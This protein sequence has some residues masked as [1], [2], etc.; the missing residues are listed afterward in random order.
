MIERLFLQLW[1]GQSWRYYPLRW[2]LM[3]ITMLF[4]L[5]VRLRYLGYRKGWL[6]HYRPS[7]PVIVVGNLTVGGT[8]KTPLVIALCTWLRS[9]GYQPAVISRGYGRQ[10]ESA[11]L[12]VTAESDPQM[13]GDEPLLIARASGCEVYVSSDRSAAAEMAESDGA[14]I[15]VADD[16]LQHYRLARDIE[17][18]VIDGERG[19]GNGLCLPA[20]PLREPA[21]RLDQVDGVVVNGGEGN[22]TFSMQLK[23]AL[24]YR[25][26]Q[27]ERQQD[28]AQLQGRTVHAVAGIGNPDRFF[29]LLRNHGATVIPHPFPDHHHYS[30][31]DLQFNDNHPVVMTEKDAVKCNRLPAQGQHE[32][33]VIV[34]ESKLDPALTRLL[35]GRLQT[36]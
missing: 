17:L 30:A 15:I 13:V 23:P 8:G 24:V 18:I 14:D 12:K 36:Q 31:S 22:G 35:Q 26:D 3:P 29:S 5:V 34:V 16:G 7:V 28:I 20:G 21:E 19:L 27:P 1:Y 2:L 4:C 25:L 6:R 10:D 32:Q 11:L 33:W 9:M